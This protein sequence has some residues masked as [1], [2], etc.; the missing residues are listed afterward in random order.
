MVDLQEFLMGYI[1]RPM[2]RGVD[3]CSMLLADWWRANH[4]VDPASDLRGSYSSEEE[5][6][7]IISKAGGLVELISGIASKVS[8]SLSAGNETGS[9]GVV[10]VRDGGAI[11]AIRS[12]RYW[13]ARS[14]TGIAFTSGVRILRAWSIE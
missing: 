7:E 9:F 8:A 3:D 1:D 2:V 5:Q 12:G 4:G 10:V 11:G 14:E 6:V 13:C